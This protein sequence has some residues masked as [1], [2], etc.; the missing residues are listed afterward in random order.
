MKKLTQL[1]QQAQDFVQGSWMKALLVTILLTSP[2]LPVNI[3][4]IGATATAQQSISGEYSGAEQKF[5]NLYKKIRNFAGFL[6]IIA[7]V[8]AGILFVTGKTT[9]A[10]TVFVGAVIVFG[11]AYVIELVMSGLT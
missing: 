5:N 7:T 3:P 1:L 9:M 4:L 8:V 6:L 10:V 2:M 11:G